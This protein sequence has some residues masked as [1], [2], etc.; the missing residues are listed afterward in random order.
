MP[1]RNLESIRK[2]KEKGIAVYLTAFFLLVMIPIVGLSIDGGYAF[3]I[4][5]RLSAAADSAALAAG[6][7]VNLNGTIAQADAQATTQ[8]TNFFNSD[9]PSGY[10]NTSTSNRVVTPTFTVNLDSSGNPTGILTISVTASVVA[11]TYFMQWL[12]IPSLTVTAAGTATRKNLVMEIVLDTSASMNTRTGAQVGKIPTSLATTDTS[13]QAMVYAVSQFITYFSPYDTI[14]DLTFDLT[15]YDDNNAGTNNGEK[16]GSYNAST[17]YWESGSGG[18]DNS[19]ENIQC[20]SN[21]NTTA[22][23]YQAYQDIKAVNEKLAQNV[24]V[25]F[26]DGVPNAVNGTFPV[27][28]Y[29]DSRMSPAQASGSS[30]GQGCQDTNG[31]TL[32]ISTTTNAQACT[33]AGNAATGCKAGQ[34]TAG[35][36]APGGLPSCT[37]TANQTVTAAIAQWANFDVNG[38]QRGAAQMFWN[39]SA[40]GSITGCPDYTN[41]AFSSQTIAYIPN[42]DYFGNS[43]TTIQ[44]GGS[45]TATSPWFQWIYGDTDAT[46]DHVNYTCAPSGVTITSG[47]SSCKNLGDFWTNHSTLGAGADHNTFQTGPYTGYLRPDTPNSIGTA[48]MTSATNMAFTIKS[49]TT[50]NPVI[51]VVYLQ[52][53]G[54]DPVDR[55]FLQLVSNQQYIQPLVYQ[56]SPACPDGALDNVAN[57]STCLVSGNSLGLP[58]GTFT[59]PYFQSSQQEGL[60]EQTADTLQLESMFQAIASSLL[61]ISQ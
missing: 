44:T 22:A 13:C 60:W 41:Y 24:I 21:T 33:A 7:G 15:V 56:S 19:L 31:T 14:G 5:S 4:Q 53:N 2:A 54:S 57:A 61:R 43:F 35:G 47:N 40:P 29:V 17:N 10:M 12:G 11:P 26:T 1:S 42:T 55:S 37:E 58:A 59:N 46:A 32:C 23:L 51:D 36:S 3:V 9:F 34:A 27:R 38:G 16:D 30:S 18:M 49:D 48:S 50:Y 52:G 20:G 39:S 8:A 45:S 6:R 25:L 28:T